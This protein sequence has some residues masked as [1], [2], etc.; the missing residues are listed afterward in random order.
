MGTSR[1][2]TATLASPAE[3]PSEDTSDGVLHDLIQGALAAV[4]ADSYQTAAELA[5]KALNID[6]R[7][8]HAW[9]LLG[10][11]REKIGDPKNAIAAYEAALTLMPAQLDIATDLGR[12]NFQLGLLAPA[13][14]FFARVHA[15]QPGVGSA[16]NLACALRELHEFDQAIE[17]LRPAIESHPGAALLWNTLGTVLDHRGD[18]AGAVTFFEEALRLDPGHV[19]ARHNLGG[20][21]LA[22]G[23]AAGALADCD[24]AMALTTSPAE[25][26]F[27]RL[28]RST[29]LFCQGRV[30]E[31]WDDYEARIDPYLADGTQF[32]L[33]RPCWDLT[34]DIT[35]KS[36][37][38]FGEQGLGDSVAFAGIVPD[39]LHELGPEGRLT[40]AVEPRLI[41][42]FQRAFPTTTV[43]PLS[44][45][46]HNSRFVRTLPNIDPST[47]DLWTP[48]A[49]P[50]RRYRRTL[51]DYPNQPF[52][53]VANADRVAHWRDALSALPG[54]KVGLA[55][56]SLNLDGIRSKFFPT[57]ETMRPVLQTPGVTFVNLQYGECETELAA[58]RDRFGVDIWRPPGIDLKDDLE[59][60]AALS[61]AMDVVLGPANATTS[62]AGSC[63]A[64]LWMIAPPASWPCHGTDRYPFYPQSRGFVAAGYGQWDEV[65]DR[66]ATALTEEV[67][68]RS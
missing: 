63:G 29:I 30:G 34:S 24:A 58:A 35:G 52:T 54:L 11:A 26:A 19:K 49:S 7:N 53:L 10:L 66:V 5:I 20:A 42:L 15:A 27:M 55:W 21:K 12:L 2:S 16:N 59:E 18:P 64:P 56:K 1:S 13:T 28:A 9:Y 47:F 46:K 33:D 57:F 17:I 14:G 41:T 32:L 51:A 40:I 62:I 25:L 36:L 39:L 65:V 50:H 61:C 67:E 43:V 6:E 44:G 31:G 22:L 68:R 48:M 4:K 3:D 45:F 60:I 8:G 38:L 23:D 37:L